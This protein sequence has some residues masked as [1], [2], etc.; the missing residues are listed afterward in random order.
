MKLGSLTS[1]EVEHL[2]SPRLNKYIPKTLH[3]HQFPSPKQ[4][5]FL[6]LDHLEAFYG[7][8]A[9]GGKSAALLA[10]ALQYVDLPN[11]DALI[12]RRTFT[13]LA[14]PGALMDMSHEW[15]A[16][17]DAVW[18]GTDKKWLFPS[19]ATLSFGHI[20]NENDKYNFQGPSYHFVAFDELTQFSETQYRYLFTRLRKP[21]DSEVP[22]R[23]RATSNPGGTGHEWV[24]KRF[25]SKAG[26]KEGRVFIPAKATD[27]P[28]ADL[29]SY[30]QSLAEVDP[31]LRKQMEEGD[32][33]AYEGGR[34]Q[35]EWFRRWEQR[36]DKYWLQGR[37]E[38]V[39]VPHCHRFTICDPA[40]TA[41]ENRAAA[42]G[43]DSDYT[44][45]GTFAVTPQRDVLLLD[46]VRVRIRVDEIVPLLCEVATGWK[47]SWVGIE[48]TN[49]TWALVYQAQRL[50]GMPAVKPLEPHGKGKLARATPA[51]NA[52]F[53]GQIFFPRA[54]PWLEDF[55]AELVQ[56][57]GDEKLDAHDDQVDV[58]AYAVQERDRTGTPEIIMPEQKPRDLNAGR[59][60]RSL[61]GGRG[62]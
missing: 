3:G 45:I 13:Q 35:R 1:A 18:T 61:F 44:A 30:G 5:A 49:F 50:K 37:L 8:A 25:V 4:T 23:M 15:L 12:L 52:C 27:N 47:S 41:E 59:S 54:A 14:K 48:A 6:I 51:I 42:S 57:T 32:W 20:E 58:L 34:F 2:L 26:R 39:H 38:P 60:T 21:V 31:I 29:E 19:G 43:K 10:A 7:G 56:F 9:F 16:G 24:K 22:I 28:G 53:G 17:T 11:Y 46:M 40:A 33:D 62:R 55:E 36:G